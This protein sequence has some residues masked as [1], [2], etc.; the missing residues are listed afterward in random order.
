M[1]GA[2]TDGRTAIVASGD[3]ETRILLRGLL[4]LHHV[5]VE[6]EAPGGRGALELIE[7]VHPSLLVVDVDL[8]EGSW[9]ELLAGARTRV[10]GLHVILIAPSARPPPPAP[11]GK[12][13]DVTLLRP[14]RIRAFAD[15][16]LSADREGPGASPGPPG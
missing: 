5:R 13:P 10:P 7:R 6:G 2:E 8:S 3:E 11:P 16:L 14:F 1:H 4:R 12:G 9:N 15:A